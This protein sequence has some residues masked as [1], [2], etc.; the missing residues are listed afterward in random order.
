MAAPVKFFSTLTGVPRLAGRTTDPT[1]LMLEASDER[2]AQKAEFV[3]AAFDSLDV[4]SVKFK[5]ALGFIESARTQMIGRGSP[6]PTG[7]VGCDVASLIQ[8]LAP[9]F[10]Q[11]ETTTQTIVALKDETLI[12]FTKWF[13][14]CRFVSYEGRITWLREDGSCIDGA[15]K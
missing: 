4:I 10:V 12:I 13:F 5:T 9:S 8:R 7:L 11:D 1:R 14:S 2:F 3:R 6:L 15:G